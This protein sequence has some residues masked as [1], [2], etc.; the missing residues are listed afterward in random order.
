MEKL[1]VKKAESHPLLSGCGCL[2]HAGVSAG[3]TPGAQQIRRGGCPDW[4]RVEVSGS[5][6]RVE[7]GCRPALARALLSPIFGRVGSLCCH[8]DVGALMGW[9]SSQGWWW[10]GGGS[11]TVQRCPKQ[12]GGTSAVQG[13]SQ[14][15]L[16][17]FPALPPREQE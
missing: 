11:S 17:G 8:G 7:K 14:V 2:G 6:V 13:H 9:N 1:G 3:Q 16:G 5:P 12:K 10:D 15:Q 4:R